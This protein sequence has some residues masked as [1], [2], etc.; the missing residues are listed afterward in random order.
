[1][2]DIKR[3]SLPY[4]EFIFD[5]VEKC[6]VIRLKTLVNCLI[7][8][9]ENLEPEDAKK[10]ILFLQKNNVY[11]V[12]EDGYVLS[13]GTYRMKSQ[14]NNFKHVNYQGEFFLSSGQIASFTRK[15]KAIM[16]AMVVVADMM[17]Y[18]IEFKV[19]GFPWYIEFI[20]ENDYT[21]LPNILYQ[22]TKI[23][24]KSELPFAYMMA[25]EL[26]G[27]KYKYIRNCTKR[28]VIIE[29]AKKACLVPRLGF[30]SIIKIDRRFNEEF[31]IIETIPE[32]SMWLD[33]HLEKE[34]LA[35]VR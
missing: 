16:D 22:I 27:D 1:M 5:I 35:P 7:N 3:D 4:S 2:K 10:I 31:E 23:K 21:E 13:C 26:T 6:K 9:Y 12:S 15:E 24:D 8:S 25:C 34:N 32:E 30:S 28:I 17:P 29:D 20:I 33:H 11:F 18:S 19:T 14:D